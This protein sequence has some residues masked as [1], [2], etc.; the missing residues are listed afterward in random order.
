MMKHLGINREIEY[1]VLPD[2]VQCHVLMACVNIRQFT[3]YALHL[4]I[5]CPSDRDSISCSSFS[6]ISPS[7]SKKSQVFLHL[8]IC[9]AQ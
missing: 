4:C 1:T 7:A 3:T 8:H 9:E 6:S 5:R 2:G